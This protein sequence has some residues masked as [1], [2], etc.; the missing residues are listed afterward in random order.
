MDRAGQ[1]HY[2]EIGNMLRVR[3]LLLTLGLVLALSASGWAE[4]LAAGMTPDEHACCVAMGHDCASDGMDMAC[5]SIE[6]PTRDLGPTVL[7]KQVVDTL[8][9]VTGPLAVDAVPPPD[10]RT[11]VAASR[12]FERE[13]WKFPDRPTYLR[14][15]VFLL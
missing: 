1:S 8:I 5:C 2:H 9:V 15:S 10:A 14:L 7:G 11:S 4:C 3:R 6:R 12:A 13:P